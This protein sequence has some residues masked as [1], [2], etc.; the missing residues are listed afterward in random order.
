HSTLLDLSATLGLLLE[1]EEPAAVVVKPTTPCGAA[2]AADVAAAF[3]RARA[4]DPVSIYG[5]IVG[6]NRPVDRALLPALGGVLLEIL[7]APPLDAAALGQLR[8][9]QK[10]LPGVELARRRPGLPPRPT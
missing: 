7:F 6:V 9:A 10:K 4:S 2:V 5:G 3:E 8:R 1:F